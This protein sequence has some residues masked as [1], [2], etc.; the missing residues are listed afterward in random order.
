MECRRADGHYRDPM[1]KPVLSTYTIFERVRDVPD[2]RFVVRRFDI[3]DQGGEPKPGP[4]IGTADTLEG[5]RALVP[6]TADVC[7]ARDPSDDLVI[8]ETWL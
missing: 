4:I 8:V 5:A 6:S 3:E 2:A 7:L 1:P